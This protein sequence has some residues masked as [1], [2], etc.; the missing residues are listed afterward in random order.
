MNK[1]FAIILIFS[2]F[3]FHSY[4]D[5]NEFLKTLKEAELGDP[6]SQ[7][8]VAHMYK[9]GLG[10]E[11]NLLKALS[12]YFKAGEQNQVN[13]LT[14]IASY[15]LDGEA[16]EQNYAVAFKIYKDAANM[17]YKES[18]IYKIAKKIMKIKKFFFYKI[19]LELFMH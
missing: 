10:T 9:N 3:S 7:N 1:F 8:N 15:Y 4:S 18:A 16:V 6:I 11:K 14:T 5:E 2:T 19:N 17:R 12:W 13:A